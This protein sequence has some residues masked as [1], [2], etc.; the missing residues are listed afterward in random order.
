MKKQTKKR[1][2]L[3]NLTIA[4]LMQTDL[5]KMVGGKP[6]VTISACKGGTDCTSIACNL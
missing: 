6:P 1:L 2:N 5:D 3:D 4:I